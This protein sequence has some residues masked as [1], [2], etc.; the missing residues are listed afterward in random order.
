[1]TDTVKINWAEWKIRYDQMSKR[2]TPLHPDA[3]KGGPT[4]YLNGPK[5]KMVW[6][7]GSLEW[8]EEQKRDAG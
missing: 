4:D 7:I 5:V 2:E 1:M 8:S 6:A 3:G